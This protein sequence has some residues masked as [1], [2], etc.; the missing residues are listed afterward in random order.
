[1]NKKDQS[2]SITAAQLSAG[3]KDM[4]ISIVSAQ[5]QKASI[6]LYDANGRIFLN[7]PV[8]LQKGI[9]TINKNIPAVAKGIYYVKVFTTDEMTVKNI[10][11]N[12]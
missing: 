4:S 12:D 1:M 11:V 2:L 3:R 6:A 7:E 8:V 10:L 9:N 5:N